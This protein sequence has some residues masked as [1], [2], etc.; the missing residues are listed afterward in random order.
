MQKEKHYDKEF[1]WMNEMK[2]DLVGDVDS[3]GSS[4]SHLGLKG[5]INVLCDPPG[6]SNNNVEGEVRGALVR[7]IR[8]VSHALKRCFQVE[9][10]KPKWLN[11]CRIIV[12]N[13]IK[14]MKRPIFSNCVWARKSQDVSGRGTC[15][16]QKMMSEVQEPRNKTITITAPR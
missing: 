9:I 2:N 8:R 14:V 3:S 12:C 13:M 16:G 1:G 10:R 4:T 15:G 6:L 11:Q 7:K 5:E